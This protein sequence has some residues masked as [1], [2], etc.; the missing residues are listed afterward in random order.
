MRRFSQRE[1]WCKASDDRAC[2]GRAAAFFLVLPLLVMTVSLAAGSAFADDAPASRIVASEQ[3]ES[4]LP[5]LDHLF[6]IASSDADDGSSL[7]VTPL[8]TMAKLA[9]RDL[10]ERAIAYDASPWRADEFHPSLGEDRPI[11]AR[12][13][14]AWVRTDAGRFALARFQQIWGYPLGEVIF[15]AVPRPSGTWRDREVVFGSNTAPFPVTGADGRSVQIDFIIFINP[16]D[17][18]PDGVLNIASGGA[19]FHHTLAS[20]VFTELS[21]LSGLSHDPAREV[22]PGVSYNKTLQNALALF[23]LDAGDEGRGT[24]A[25]LRDGRLFLPQSTDP[26]FDAVGGKASPI[27]SGL[28]F[29]NLSMR[30]AHAVAPALSFPMK[31]GSPVARAD[32]RGSADPHGPWAGMAIAHDQDEY[33]T[34]IE[35]LHHHGRRIAPGFVLKLIATSDAGTSG[36]H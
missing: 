12:A 16:I 6:F 24:A 31:D 30:E 28:D 5:N 21:V 10:P 4:A 19:G 2:R 23:G 34:A 18:A 25:V 14:A 3:G 33:E 20:L 15:A 1:N 26:A 13:V 36:A 7:S 8:Q 9:Q 29:A 22:Y 32:N 35:I 11:I 17:Y 27:P